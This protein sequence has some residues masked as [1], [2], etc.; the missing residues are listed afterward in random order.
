MEQ[1]FTSTSAR[2]TGKRQTTNT[3]S[4][5]RNEK[6]RVKPTAHPLLPSLLW[7]LDLTRQGWQWHSPAVH[8]ISGWQQAAT[9]ALAGEGGEATRQHRSGGFVLRLQDCLKSPT[10][11]NLSTAEL[12]DNSAGGAP[13]NTLPEQNNFE[14]NYMSWDLVLSL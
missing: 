14:G 2:E 6:C 5:P 13:G 3:Q 7:G 1:L 11:A 9:V 8:G 10:S 4:G 12:P